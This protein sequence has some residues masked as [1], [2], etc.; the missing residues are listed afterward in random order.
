M[1]CEK[2]LTMGLLPA[3]ERGAKA[4]IA[5]ENMDGYLSLGLRR[6]RGL[7]GLRGLNAALLSGQWHVEGSH[8]SKDWG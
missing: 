7:R 8:Q 2:S 6:L 5:A 3:D 4:L 1:K